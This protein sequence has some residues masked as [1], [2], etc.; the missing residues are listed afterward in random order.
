MLSEN[1]PFI[2]KDVDV[3][4]QV[5]GSPAQADCQSDPQTSGILYGQS[6]TEK[7][8]RGFSGNMAKEDSK[9]QESLQAKWKVG[10]E[11]TV[12]S[13]ATTEAAPF[14]VTAYQNDCD[15]TKK[16]VSLAAKK[17]ET[18]KNANETIRQH[19]FKAN[20]DGAP[21]SPL[22][23]FPLDP[24]LIANA[25]QSEEFAG[26]NRLTENVDKFQ[27]ESKPA[28]LLEMEEQSP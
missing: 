10:I 4:K 25:S 5:Q 11:N 23:T 6:E 8:E 24:N 9:M 22:S 26:I 1:S 20:V 18:I 17:T 7:H 3:T 27:K 15:V 12:P 13:P 19:K 2:G 14:G 16:F 28:W 21:S